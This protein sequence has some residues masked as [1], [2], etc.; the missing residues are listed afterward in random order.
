MKPAPK[1][2]EIPINL[3]RELI[4]AVIA[5][6]D[7]SDLSP[8]E[9][10][11]RA[12]FLGL[13]QRQS[14]RSVAAPKIRAHC[15]QCGEQTGTAFKFMPAGIGNACAVCGSFRKGE[16]YISRQKFQTLMPF[17]AK[18]ENLCTVDT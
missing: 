17:A 14:Q 7:E 11:H 15:H 12:A 2:A 10:L 1:R 16:P 5:A 18:G 8:V 3:R 13:K 4:D 9:I 6:S